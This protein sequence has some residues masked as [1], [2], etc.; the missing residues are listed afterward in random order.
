MLFRS[1]RGRA[2]SDGEPKS[3][4][5]T[6]PEQTAPL[7]E[8]IA[9]AGAKG[10]GVLVVGRGRIT[11]PEG[12]F[13]AEA[14][15]IASSFDGSM[16]LVSARGAHRSD[17]ANTPLDIL[18]PMTGAPSSRRGAELAVRVASAAGASLTAL[19]VSSHG[20]VD[21]ARRGSLQPKDDNIALVREIV[22]L[23]EQY[24]VAVKTAV[25][26]NIAPADAILRQARLGDHNLIVMGVTKRPG[27]TL[28]FGDVAAAMLESSDRSLVFVSSGQN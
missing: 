5:L 25:R 28:S 10:H 17:P 19:I 4:D 23:G 27:D 24:G 7:R 11:A 6:I 1:A 16:V 8:T 9:A 21:A 18:A 12:G 20:A 2:D 22:R 14:G 13:S 3:V 26:V 15:E